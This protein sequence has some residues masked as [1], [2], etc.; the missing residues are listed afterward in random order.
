MSTLLLVTYARHP[1][2]VD[3]CTCHSDVHALPMCVHLRPQIHTL[4]RQ[5][6]HVGHV[7]IDQVHATCGRLHVNVSVASLILAGMRRYGHEGTLVCR[8]SVL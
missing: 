5:Y 2:S 6:S 1:P 3:S 8:T 7:H 4:R